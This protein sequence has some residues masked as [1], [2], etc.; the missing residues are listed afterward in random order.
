MSEEEFIELSEKERASWEVNG[1]CVYYGIGLLSKHLSDLEVADMYMISN[2]NGYSVQEV[3]LKQ[4]GQERVLVKQGRIVF[5]EG[6]FDG[7]ESGDEY[8]V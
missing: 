6:F 4:E 2:E 5:W 3:N 1:Q 8:F 7:E